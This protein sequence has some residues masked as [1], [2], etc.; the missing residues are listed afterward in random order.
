MDELFVDQKEDW[1]EPPYVD[2]MRQMEQDKMNE[3][4]WN[5]RD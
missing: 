2:E 3:H 5:P 4:I 1:P